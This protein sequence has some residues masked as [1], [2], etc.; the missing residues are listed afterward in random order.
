MFLFIIL[1]RNI[2]CKS[3]L[4]KTLNQIGLVDSKFGRKSRHKSN[5]QCVSLR[6]RVCFNMSPHMILQSA[7]QFGFLLSKPCLFCLESSLE[8]VINRGKPQ[9][10]SL[11]VQFPDD[12][13]EFHFCTTARGNLIIIFT[14]TYLFRS[15]FL[16]RH[17]TS[18]N[19]SKS[20][21]RNNAKYAFQYT[22][23]NYTTQYAKK[24]KRKRKSKVGTFKTIFAVGAHPVPNP[25]QQG[26]T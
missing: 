7:F 14:R 17:V 20:S 15:R 16:A 21:G 25:A 5:F 23:K 24:E 8:F 2:D 4:Q 22:F 26:L 1:A 11:P 13:S 12:R 19:F 10:I 9:I 3:I 18:Q 6:R